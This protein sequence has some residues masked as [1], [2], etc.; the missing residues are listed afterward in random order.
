MK[1][2]LALTAVAL[3]A[4]LVLQWKDWPPGPSQVGLDSAPV[5][6]PAGGTPAD[7]NPWA[8]PAP[9]KGRE[10]YASV[11][12]RTLFRP[13]RRPPDP[14]TDETAPEPETGEAA[15]L[16]GLDLSAVVIAPG[17]TQA[18]VADPR[19]GI[20]RLHLGD[21]YEGWTVKDITPDTLVLERQGKTNTLVL[22]DFAQAPPPAAQAPAPVPGRQPPGNQRAPQP[23]RGAQ[24]PRPDRRVAPPRPP[25]GSQDASPSASPQARPNARRPPPS[26]PE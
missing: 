17:T 2:L 19:Q 25:P 16:E 12:E 9:L 1:A 21:I 6:D 8:G 15:S 11:N 13:Q 4:L 3:A 22:R 23:P 10:T 24:A 7:P 18:W 14:V 26:R 5:A 20:K